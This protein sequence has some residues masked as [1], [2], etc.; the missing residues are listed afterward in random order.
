VRCC[1]ELIFGTKSKKKRRRSF[2]S[3]SK[4]EFA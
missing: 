4:S 2:R 3:Y 1:R